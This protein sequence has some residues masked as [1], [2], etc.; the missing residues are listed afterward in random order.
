M[1]QFLLLLKLNL[2]RMLMTN[3]GFGNRKKARALGGGTTV[4]LLCGTMLYL[5]GFYSR[6]ILEALVPLGLE[7]LLFSLMG[8]VVVV[9]GLMFT[10]LGAGNTLFSGKDNDLLLSMPI[11]ERKLLASRVSAIYLENL[12]FSF[13]I[14]IPAG[15]MYTVVAGEGV[16]D[17]VGFWG[18]TLI[19]VLMLPM[20]DTTLAVLV[21][22]LISWVASRV[23]HRALGQ[24]I[25]MGIYLAGVCLFAFNIE[26]LV[27]S[28]ESFAFWAQ[29]GMSRLL[30]IH[31]M[32]EGIF[33]DLVKLA[34]FS[35][36]CMASLAAVVM[37]LGGTFRRL[38]L[39]AGSVGSGSDYRLTEL[40]INTPVHALLKKEARRFFGTPIYFWNGMFVYLLLVGSGIFALIKRDMIAAMTPVMTGEWGV[41]KVWIVFGAAG[42]IYSMAEVSAPSFSLEGNK[43]WILRQSPLSERMLISVKT[44]FELMIGA[45]FTLTGVICA[46]IACGIGLAEWIWLGIYLVTFMIL[47]ATFG[48]LMG[49]VFVRLDGDDTAILK[50]SLSGVLSVFVPIVLLLIM[51]A[52][53]ILLLM[54]L[55]PVWVVALLYA[56]LA[57]LTVVCTWLL[58][59]VGPKILKHL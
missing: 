47:H 30:P 23:R 31:W 14:L 9:S 51:A 4:L 21:G 58:Y 29:K 6:T 13:F 42:F 1:K 59:T 34:G 53:G 46:G 24:S 26:R 7:K 50:R 20:L 11:G 35:G 40:K 55:S 45:P 16:F 8:I 27:G 19:G 3:L 49:L 38:T 57:A 5:S 2:M 10:A 32:T 54:R 15:A 43:I 18:R 28:L 36:I 52:I 48:T 22:A 44:G 56:V 37:L 41:L 17:T 33:G 39:K 12:M 25:L